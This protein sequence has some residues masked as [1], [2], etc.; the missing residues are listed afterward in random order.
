MSKKIASLMLVAVVISVFVFTRTKNTPTLDFRDAM[1]DDFNTD[2]SSIEQNFGD[3]PIPTPNAHGKTDTV[4]LDISCGSFGTLAERIKDCRKNVGNHATFCGLNTAVGGLRDCGDSYKDR[5][6]STVWLLVTRARGKEVW[7]ELGGNHYL[8]AFDSATNPR[9]F[10][11]ANPREDICKNFREEYFDFKG[12]RIPAYDDLKRAGLLDYSV[13]HNK[14]FGF[15]KPQYNWYATLDGF[16][17]KV[18]RVNE[19]KADTICITKLAP[20][21]KLPS[22]FD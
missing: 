4:D 6:L 19:A 12:F 13:R 18:P 11:G 14:W 7:L 1:A 15:F 20:N 17:I 22:L 5:L 9:K 3:I 8:W 16:T 2:I 10:A 21:T